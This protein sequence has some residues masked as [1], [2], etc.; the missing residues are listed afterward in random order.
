MQPSKVHMWMLVL[1]A[2]TAVF[3]LIAVGLL[4]TRNPNSGL[5]TSELSAACQ[6]GTINGITT[7]LTRIAEACSTAEPVDTSDITIK[8]TERYPGFISPTGWHVAGS[9]NNSIYT[10]AMN[11]EPMIIHV[12]D[13]EGTNLEKISIS[14]TELPA[15]AGSDSSAYVASLFSDSRFSEK[16]TTSQTL[17]NGTLYTTTLKELIEI[18]MGD[19]PQTILHFF[20]PTRLI[21]VNYKIGTADAAWATIEDSLDWSTV[22]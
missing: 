12:F 14:T 2:W 19:H 17:T 9:W 15:G 7:N 13:S 11:N 16:S 18:D 20:T 1:L 22:K 21:T 4:L 3:S 6:N 8:G 5:S 10:I